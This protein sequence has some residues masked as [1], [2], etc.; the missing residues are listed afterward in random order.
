MPYNNSI[1]LDKDFI[2]KKLTLSSL[3]L[4]AAL[5]VASGTLP[6]SAAEM[7][8][9]AG[10]CGA[11]MSQNAAKCG[12]GKKDGTGR[13]A[14]K[15]GKNN[16]QGKGVGKCGN[17]KKDGTGKGAGKCGKKDGSGKGTTQTVE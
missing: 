10:K 8:C 5:F 16:G 4:G 11:S 17:G 15:C 6:L 3:L 1:L 13:G 2:M 9:G 14:G 12:K 7:K